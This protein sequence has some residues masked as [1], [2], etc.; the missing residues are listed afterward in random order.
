MG[1]NNRDSFGL[2]L[3]RRR[4]PRAGVP[5]D[6][7][8]R[9]RGGAGRHDPGRGRQPATSSAARSPTPTCS[10]NVVASPYGFNYTGDRLLQLRRITTLTA[11]R[12]ILRRRRR[13]RH[14]RRR[15]DRRQ[16]PAH[17]SILA[18]DLQDATQS[19]TFTIEATVTDESDQAV[20]GRTDV[21]VHQ[22]LLYVGVQPQEY[23]TQAEQRDRRST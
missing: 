17:V 10:Y 6:A 23:V 22:G 21:I 13:H 18:A 2:R 9:R 11:R 4:I 20:S 19:Q 8:R 5:G 12:R 15:H 7:S 14:Q 3:R 16:R 1:S